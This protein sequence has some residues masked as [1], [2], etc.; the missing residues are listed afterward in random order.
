M[1]RSQQVGRDSFGRS[2]FQSGGNSRPGHP[3]VDLRRRGCLAL[4]PPA[5]RQQP[6]RR[7]VSG[8]PRAGGPDDR[9][10]DVPVA[11]VN[12]RPVVRGAVRGGDCRAG[13]RA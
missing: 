3:L 10:A 2:A 4:F 9:A 8:R 12:S 7:R 11:D 13:Y 5:K 6:A 1:A